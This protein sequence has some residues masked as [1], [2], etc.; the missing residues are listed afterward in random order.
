MADVDKWLSDAAQTARDAGGTVDSD[1]I[2]ARLSSR[3]GATLALAWQDARL[4]MLCAALASAAAMIVF[5]GSAGLASP[6]FQDRP[7]AMWLST[8]PAAS[9]F[10]LLVGV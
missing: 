6:K 9:P 10:G 5:T 1:K 3:Q 8:P 7:E 4:V 2:M